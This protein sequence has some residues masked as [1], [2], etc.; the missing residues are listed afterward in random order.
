MGELCHTELCV[1]DEATPHG[2][3]DAAEVL[4]ENARSELVGAGASGVFE[5]KACPILAKAY[6]AMYV[7]ET[8]EQAE[9]VRA[10]RMN[11]G[12]ETEGLPW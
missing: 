7:A 5:V 8:P 2:A 11:L 3:R 6:L 12:W 10:I 1:W 9:R 4:C